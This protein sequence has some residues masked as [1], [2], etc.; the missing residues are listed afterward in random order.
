MFD[1]LI[2]GGNSSKKCSKYFFKNICKKVLFM[3]EVKAK[4]MELISRESEMEKE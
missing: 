2:L 4:G 3:Y 1:T